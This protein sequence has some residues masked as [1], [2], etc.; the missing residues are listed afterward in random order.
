LRKPTPELR[1]AQFE[2]VSQDIQEWDVG[3]DV[4]LV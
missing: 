1:S 2:I 4:D 3:G